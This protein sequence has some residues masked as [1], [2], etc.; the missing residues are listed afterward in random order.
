M[1]PLPNQPN[2]LREDFLFQ[3]GE[4]TNALCRLH[5]LW[6]GVTPTAATLNAVAHDIGVLFSANLDILM[7]IENKLTSVVVTDLTTPTSAVGLDATLRPGTNGG[8]RL[9]GEV[10]MMMN[11][12]ILRRYR[13]GKPRVYWPFGTQAD[14]TD[15]QLWNPGILASNLTAMNAFLSGC[16]AISE[17]GTLLGFNVSISYYSGFTAVV[18]PITGRTRD[19][20]KVRAVA[21]PPDVVQS[22]SWHPRPASQRR[23]SLNRP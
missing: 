1:P 3:V 16:H 12:H 14:L 5:Q 23:R 17:S 8:G 21:I 6:S 11:E 22:I 4:D 18:N 19:V 15:E 2:V 9:P 20:P 7:G 13:G 10:A